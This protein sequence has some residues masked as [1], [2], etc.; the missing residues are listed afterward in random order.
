MNRIYTNESVSVHCIQRIIN[1]FLVKISDSKLEYSDGF[2]ECWMPNYRKGLCLP[3]KDC[4]PLNA[5]ANKKRLRMADRLFLKRSLCGHIGLTPLVCCPTVENITT[6]FDGSPL[7]LDDL[8]TDCGK[9]HLNHNLRLEYIV[10]GN[11]A[12]IYDSPWLTLLEYEKS[13]F[14]IRFR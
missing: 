7:T 1:L 11:E 12:R 4:S 10:G 9:I 8:P 13:V 14:F 3:L 6:R 2:G 5:L